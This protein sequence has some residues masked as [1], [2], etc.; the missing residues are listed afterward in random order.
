[1]IHALYNRFP[2]LLLL[3]CATLAAE[4]RKSAKLQATMK[5]DVA[6]RGSLKLDSAAILVLSKHF[7]CYEVC[8]PVTPL[9][10]ADLNHTFVNWSSV[11]AVSHTSGVADMGCPTHMYP[12]CDACPFRFMAAISCGC[13]RF[14]RL[15]QLLANGR[16]G[17]RRLQQACLPKNAC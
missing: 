4:I 11:P 7:Q 6:G 1:M 12:K 13:V 17:T 10:I 16:W 2:A 9:H 8:R 5:I 14:A 3:L 15:F